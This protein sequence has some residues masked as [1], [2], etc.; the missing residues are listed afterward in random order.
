MWQPWASAMGRGKR[1][2]TRHWQPSP[3]Y[4]GKRFAI[5]AAKRKIDID[6]AFL[7]GKE[8]GHAVTARIPGALEVCGPVKITRMDAF[9]MGAVVTTATLVDVFEI[10]AQP[11]IFSATFS[12]DPFDPVCDAR[13]MLP[14]ED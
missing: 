10:P 9:P 1:F 11:T 7:L 3:R 8:S 2:E 12:A 13:F 14:P 6:G 4:I 5:H